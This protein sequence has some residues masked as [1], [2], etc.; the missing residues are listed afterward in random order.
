MNEDQK[1]AV[2][3]K[4][5][6][7]EV[8]YLSETSRWRLCSMGNLWFNCRCGST[9]MIR[10]GKFPWYSPERFLQGEAKSVFNQLGNLKDLPHV[11]AAVMDLQKLLQDPNVTPKALVHELRREPAIAVE[12]LKV[13][14]NLR[15]TRNPINPPITALEHAIVYIGFKTLGDLLVSSAI[16]VIPLPKSEFDAEVFWREAYIRGAIAEVLAMRLSLPYTP[17]EVY[18]AASLC[19]VGK[20]VTAYCFPPLATKLARAVKDTKELSTWRKA[21]AGYQFPEHT[22]LGEIAATL[23]GFPTPIL[24]AARHHHTTPKAPRPG[25]ALT[26]AALV[27]GANQLT[28]WVLLQPHR[29]E[30]PVLDAFATAAG[31]SEQDIEKLAR[32]LMPLRDSIGAQAAA[33]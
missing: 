15:R 17:D 22:I 29:M 3:G 25:Q 1:C 20:L 28:H 27:A 10:K 16:K 5:Y 32:E 9:H 4:P 26:L 31:Y 2:C 7:T 18:L 12:T 13:A 19:D 30:Q 11:P 14:E 23:W 24:E 33:G 21:E 8:D 6:L